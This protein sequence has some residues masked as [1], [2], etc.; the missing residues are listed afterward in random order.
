MTD[1]KTVLVDALNASLLTDNRW[2]TV[3][4]VTGFQSDRY[5]EP[6]ADG[7]IG[8]EVKDHHYDALIDADR[9]TQTIRDHVFDRDRVR[10]A[11]VN[12]GF[13]YDEGFAG[14]DDLPPRPAEFEF[15]P[16][17]CSIADDLIDRLIEGLA[18]GGW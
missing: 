9:L 12:I 7:L 17:R 16:H 5:P 6:Y 13:K 4:F 15:T 10:D 18:G 11:L 14:S 2:K 1:L 3:E 8:V